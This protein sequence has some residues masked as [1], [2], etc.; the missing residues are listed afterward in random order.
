MIRFTAQLLLGEV[1]KEYFV[2][3]APWNGSMISHTDSREVRS[4]SA[5]RYAGITR[6]RAKNPLRGSLVPWR[7][8]TCWKDLGSSERASCATV[9]GSPQR[10]PRRSSFQTRLSDLIPTA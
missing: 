3:V 9:T 6:C 4:S 2:S 7:Q 5:A 10:Q 1:A 8:V